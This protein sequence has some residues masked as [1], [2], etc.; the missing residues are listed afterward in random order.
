M[1]DTIAVIDFGS[2]TSQLITRRVRE[3][4]VYC[5]LFA[6]D[7]PAEDILAINPSGYIL[8]GGPASIYEE[9]APKIP[10]FV[11]ESGQP[12]LGICYGMQV[13]ADALGGE[14][15]PAQSR[16][17]GVAEIHV[18]DGDGLLELGSQPVWMSHGDRVE[19]LPSGFQVIASSNNSPYA[20]MGDPT[21]RIYG[22]QFHPEV[23]HTPG[24]SEILRRFAVDICR[25][26]AN[27]SPSSNIPRA[28]RDIQKQV[29]E[30]AQS[31]R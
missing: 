23:E 13:L 1:R 4:Q 11:L 31:R 24:G 9:N 14:V 22:L 27:W 2:Q 17:Y 8:S 10:E 30:E 6:Y 21:A 29:G 26:K 18:E 7:T 20:A 15:A 12:I 28:I 25:A 19:V 3:A 5:E 16:E